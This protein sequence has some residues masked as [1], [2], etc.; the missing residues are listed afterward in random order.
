MPPA[1][2]LP[3]SVA[4]LPPFVRGH[5]VCFDQWRDRGNAGW[6]YA[7][8]LPSFMRL[9]RYEAGANAYRGGDGPLSVMHCWDPHSCTGRS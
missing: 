8:V 9:E 5:Q 3:A 4:D 2:P 1:A 7:D 6:G